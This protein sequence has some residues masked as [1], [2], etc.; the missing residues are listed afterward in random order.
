MDDSSGAVS[1]GDQARALTRVAQYR[2]FLTAVVIGLSL[3]AAALEGIG[4]GFIL[5]IIEVTQ[6]EGN[7]SGAV[8]VLSNVYGALGVPFELLYIVVG[9]MLVIGVRYLAT[10][11]SG[12]MTAIL[13]MTYIRMIRTR[14]FE[15]ALNAR[16]AY[17]DEQGSDELLNAII[18]QTEYASRAIHR[19]VTLLKVFLVSVAYVVVAMYVAPYLMLVTAVVL[20]GSLF[21]IR[22]LFESGYDIGNR[23]ADANEQ[24]QTAIQAGVQGIREVKMFG[25]TDRILRQYQ[26][27]VDQFTESRIV[28]NRNQAA[29][30]S[31]SNFL[32]AAFLFLLIYVGLELMSLS[33]GGLGVFLFAM[34]RLGPQLSLMNTLVYELETDLPHLV[35]TQRFTE[36][37]DSQRDLSGEVQVSTPVERVSFEHVAFSYGNDDERVLEDVSFS[38]SRGEF[39]AFAGPSGAGKSTIVSLLARMYE[40]TSGRICA[41]GEPIADFDIEAWRDRIAIVRQD[42]YVFDETLR[43]NIMIGNPAA[44]EAELERVS[45]IAEVTEFV[46]DLSDGY[47]TS[48]GDDGVRLSG[49]QRQRVALARALLKDADLLILD[50]ATSDLDNRLERRVHRGIAQIDTEYAVVAI[51]HRLSTVADATRIHVLEDGE[52][53]ET[54]RHEE[55]VERDGTY[56][57]LLGGHSESIEHTQ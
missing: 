7:P 14:A 24:L 37:L 45:E 31:S 4:L 1:L 51:A 26:S 40:P 50:E 5:P 42:P 43:Y 27:A 25:L 46:D 33:L 10:F 17:F 20:G 49:G 15:N 29:I 11:L 47:E 53:V 55:L 18:T 16:V 57:E 8:R 22:H 52:I 12:W 30:N 38:V 21:A 48:L 28:Q 9:V 13:R 41:D 2:P 56:A 39:V 34:F 6:G 54:G 3:V 23:V 44:S 32:T 36:R 19:L 35:R